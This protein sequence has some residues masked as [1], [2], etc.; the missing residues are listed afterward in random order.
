M[1][2]VNFKKFIQ[3]KHMGDGYTVIQGT[4]IWEEGF[5]HKGLFHQWANAYEESTAGFGNYTVAL[6]EIEDGTI[7][8]VLPTS[9]QFTDKLSV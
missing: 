6:V 1:R 3:R 4:G 2:T 8:E 7:V 9:L 5:P